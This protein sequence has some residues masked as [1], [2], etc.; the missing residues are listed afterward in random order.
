ML[1]AAV[2]AT[3]FKGLGGR[4]PEELGF[5]DHFVIEVGHFAR[6]VYILLAMDAEILQE[7]LLLTGNLPR[8]KA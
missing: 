4:W 8:S 7:H 2:S 5:L 1:E 6:D 3:G